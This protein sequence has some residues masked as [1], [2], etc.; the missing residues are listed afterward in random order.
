MKKRHILGAALIGLTGLM[1]VMGSAATASFNFAD[2]ADTYA[3]ANGGHEGSWDQV[4]GGT[5]TDGAVT[6]LNAKGTFTGDAT[7]ENTHAFFDSA[8]SEGPAGLGV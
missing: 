2:L 4:T 8:G 5:L 7:G 6:I 3:G 1:P